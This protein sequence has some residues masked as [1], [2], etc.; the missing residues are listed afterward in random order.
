MG[1]TASKE[2]PALAG[3]RAVVNIDKRAVAKS[4]AAPAGV[5]EPPRQ[6]PQASQQRIELGSES[7]VEEAPASRPAVSA[8]DVEPVLAGV[9][10]DRRRLSIMRPAGPVVDPARAGRQER[11]LSSQSTS[12]TGSLSSVLS[13]P[14]E[15][16]GNGA[17]GEN[18]AHGALSLRYS[19][20]T[21]PGNDPAKRQ[22]ENQDTYCVHGGLDLDD[23]CFVACV[24]D[25]HGPNGGHASHYVRDRLVKIWREMGLGRKSCREQEEVHRILHNGCVEV[26]HKLATSS[27]DVYVSGS[28]G[29]LGV[30]KRDVLYVANVGD[31]RA[32]LGRVGAKGLLEAVD[33]SEDQKP[34]RPDEMARILRYGGRVFEWGVPRV[35]QRDVDMPGLAMARSFGDLAAESVGV[36]A[37]PEISTTKLT[38]QDKFLILATDGVWEFMSSDE[39]IQIIG[40]HMTSKPP[41]VAA[42][43]ASV[44]VIKASVAR[45]NQAEDV[46]DDSTCVIVALGCPAE[47]SAC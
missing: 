15:D 42:R 13:D 9:N 8:Q 33:L 47:L 23:E 12:S 22:K 16:V 10:G 5:A 36:W 40:K 27:I 30:I 17:F 41:H 4:A 32:V 43:D 39:V 38:A 37:E 45:W 28:T 14:G 11:S 25:G 7:K 46:V 31:S 29:I 18:G 2:G 35:W 20:V 24:F 21:R 19:C 44:E 1:C 34:D 3:P 26:N 6:A